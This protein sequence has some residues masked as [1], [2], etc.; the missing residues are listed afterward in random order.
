MIYD[1]LIQPLPQGTYNA[2]VLGWPD[3]NV[4]G[5]NEIVVVERIKK[6]IQ[7]QLAKSKILRIEV[8]AGDTKIISTDLDHPWTPFL[9]MWEDD[10]TFDDLQQRMKTYRQ[11]LD[12]ISTP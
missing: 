11:E 2:T 10:P 3:L 12:E 5:D 1:I 4:T 7:E 6:A 8:K 9:G